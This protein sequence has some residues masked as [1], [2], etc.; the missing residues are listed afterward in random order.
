MALKLQMECLTFTAFH[1]VSF[2]VILLINKK[3]GSAFPRYLE[4]IKRSC[5]AA[6]QLS[7][8]EFES[9]RRFNL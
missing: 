2:D 8:L 4:S 5:S 1:M 3:S 7:Y 6:T 9:K